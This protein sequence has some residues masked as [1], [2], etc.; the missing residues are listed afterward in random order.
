MSEF[1]KCASRIDMLAEDYTATCAALRAADKELKEIS[2]SIEERIGNEEKRQ[3]ERISTLKK[4]IADES[5]T[6]TAR[7][8]AQLELEQL[9]AQVI[10]ITPRERQA[11]QDTLSEMKDARADLVKNKGQLLEAHEKMRR[12][13]ESLRPA[14]L[15]STDTDLF[16]IWIDSAEKE[17]KNKYGDA[18]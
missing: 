11:Y 8:M 17:F 5:H 12:L 15:C 18:R 14:K 3:Q 7:R 16:Q 9:E 6:A 4:T 2:E 13:T 1:T 10:T